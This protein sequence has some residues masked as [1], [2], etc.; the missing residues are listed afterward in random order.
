MHGPISTIP[1]RASIAGSAVSDDESVLE[2]VDSG[3]S[4]RASVH[5]DA[6][7]RITFSSVYP[8]RSDS[9]NN[10]P[11]KNEYEEK[12]EA[13]DDVPITTNPMLNATGGVSRLTYTPRSTPSFT[14]TNR[15]ECQAR[16]TSAVH[17]REKNIH[18][19]SSRGMKTMTYLPSP[20]IP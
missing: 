6:T 10:S 7:A 15:T 2:S 18:S 9:T 1:G 16:L 20:P 5:G 14:L 17:E 12:Q 11:I 13:F 3:M 19:D 4:P 8:D